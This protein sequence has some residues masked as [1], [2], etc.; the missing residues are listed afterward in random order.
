MR[1][2]IHLIVRAKNKVVGLNLVGLL[3][4]AD[5]TSVFS[6]APKPPAI[7]PTI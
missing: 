4:A 1:P 7:L 2:E 5:V 6:I 3:R